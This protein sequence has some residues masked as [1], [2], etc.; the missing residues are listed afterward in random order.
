MAPI[1]QNSPSLRLMEDEAKGILH[2]GEE[3][4]KIGSKEF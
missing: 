3:L 1:P 2:F 4:R